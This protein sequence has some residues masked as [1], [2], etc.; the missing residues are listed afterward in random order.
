MSANINPNQNVVL[1]S[2]DTI[3]RNG[4]KHTTVN[5]YHSVTL[6]WLIE[7]RQGNAGTYSLEQTAFVEYDFAASFHISSY[8]TIGNRQIFY[9]YVWHKLHDSLDNTVAFHQMSDRKG[10]VYQFQHL[11][12]VDAFHPLTEFFQLACSIDSADES[13][14]RAS[15]NGSDAIAVRKQLFYGTYMG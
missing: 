10:K 8:G 7:R 4:V 9:G 14:H 6:Y 12:S 2:L 13:P 5:Q 1:L 15:G 11:L 3:Q